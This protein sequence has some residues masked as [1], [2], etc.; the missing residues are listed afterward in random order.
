M[1]QTSTKP[2]RQMSPEAAA[3]I[4]ISQARNWELLRLKGALVTL[5]NIRRAPDTLDSVAERCMHGELDVAISALSLAVQHARVRPKQTPTLS[6]QR[7]EIRKLSD[8]RR[9]VIT[10]ET[11]S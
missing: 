2:Q 3:R 9:R 10:E 1:D 7:A 4:K 11:G 8:E 5:R 6:A